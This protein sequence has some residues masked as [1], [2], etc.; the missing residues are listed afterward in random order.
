MT[1][2]GRKNLQVINLVHK[3]HAQVNNIFFND[4]F[5]SKVVALYNLQKTKELVVANMGNNKYNL[6]INILLLL[7]QV[8]I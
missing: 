7:F 6:F 5:N 3:A 1:D 8:L 4:I 2:R